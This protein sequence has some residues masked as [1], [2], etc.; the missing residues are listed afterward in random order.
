MEP[1]FFLD[2]FIVIK[3]YLQPVVLLNPELDI[4]D[5]SLGNTSLHPAINVKPR[6]LT[7][8]DLLEIK[9]IGQGQVTS[10]PKFLF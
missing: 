8:I 4:T 7:L 1:M 3:V 2:S 5:K 6:I 9:A 10:L